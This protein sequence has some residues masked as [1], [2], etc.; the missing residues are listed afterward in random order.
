MRT[1]FWF[2]I[3]V[4]VRD[5]CVAH[6]ES[7]RT[8]PSELKMHLIDELA[9]SPGGLIDVPGALRRLS[10]LVRLPLSIERGPRP[11]MHL[12]HSIIEILKVF[13]SPLRGIL[14]IVRLQQRSST[15]RI[16][17]LS[18]GSHGKLSYLKSRKSFFMNYR[19]TQWKSDLHKHYE[20]YD[21]LEVALVVGC[22]IE[23]VDRRDEWEGLCDHFQDEKYLKKVKANSIN[24]S[25]KKL[26]HQSGSRH[27]SYRL[28]Q[29]HKFPEI[30]MFNEVY[31]RPANKL[32]EH[33]YSTM[34][35]KGQTVLEEVASQLTPET[36]IDEVFPSED[37]GFQI[38]TDT[39]D[40]TLIWSG[41]RTPVSLLE[42]SR[43][44]NT[45]S[46]LFVSHN[47]IHHATFISRDN[48][49]SSIAQC[50]TSRALRDRICQPYLPL[51]DDC[52]FVTQAVVLSSYSKRF[53]GCVFRVCQVKW[54]EVCGD[55]SDEDCSVPGKDV[56]Y[57]ILLT[58]GFVPGLKVDA[59][60]LLRTIK[61]CNCS[62]DEAD[63]RVHQFF[64]T[65]YFKTGIHSL[66]GTSRSLA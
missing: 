32:T 63:I 57:D 36:P 48:A 10:S 59:I 62:R 26:L 34:V 54:E 13:L 33:L 6:W 8:I 30:D 38:M 20:K 14:D 47:D 35:E 4:L 25:K 51:H 9:V 43:A 1:I 44:T 16:I 49:L 7:W 39:L 27:F 55:G 2:D 21:G 31:V 65:S 60:L 66:P 37:A 45:H 15:V 56:T 58:V 41:G 5:K 3:G 11:V 17:A 18:C 23:L 50:L 42:V 46:S 28:E 19:F 61:I 52:P 64:K 24:W 29:R 40:Q 22:P 12:S 53:H